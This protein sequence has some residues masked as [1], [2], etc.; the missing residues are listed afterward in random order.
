MT[1]ELL[2]GQEYSSRYSLLH[3]IAR[4]EFAEVWLALDRDT[5]ERICLKVFDGN[6]EALADAL[7]AID[8]TRGLLHANIVRSFEA[9][10]IDNNL[11][12]SSTYIRS[13]KPFNPISNKFN[14]QE[15]AR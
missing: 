6:A 1:L 7:A 4:H 11:F 10:V 12:I 13:T 14:N 3:Q 15:M 8:A 5:E 2:E 9:G